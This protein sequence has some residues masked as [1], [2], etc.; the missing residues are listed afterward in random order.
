MLRLLAEEM[1]RVL[2]NGIKGFLWRHGFFLR[3]TF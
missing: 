2:P 3:H 1:S